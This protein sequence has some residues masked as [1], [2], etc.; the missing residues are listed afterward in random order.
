MKK[1]KT[2]SKKD[3]EE[4]LDHKLGQSYCAEDKNYQ[5]LP[6]SFFDKTRMQKILGMVGWYYIAEGFDCDNF[7]DKFRQQLK[8]RYWK[9]Y[10]RSSGSNNGL[11]SY[12]DIFVECVKVQYPGARLPHWFLI[13]ICDDGNGQPKIIFRER[14]PSDIVTPQ[15]G[16]DVIR[17]K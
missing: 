9:K 7:A 2:V 14:T 11:G 16:Y 8:D 1:I 10:V 15:E 6:E 3:V 13:A 5:L 4:L 17:I 12:P